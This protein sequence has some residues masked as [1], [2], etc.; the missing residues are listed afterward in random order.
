MVHRGMKGLGGVV[1]RVIF[2]SEALQV[3]RPSIPPTE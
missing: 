3:V 1:H 2:G